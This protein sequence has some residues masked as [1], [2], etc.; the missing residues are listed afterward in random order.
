MRTALFFKQQKPLTVV[1]LGIIFLVFAILALLEDATRLESIIAMLCMGCVLLGYSISF[2]MN[3][4]LNHKKHFK[5]FGV[6]AF[7]TRLECFEPEYVTV[8]STINVKSSEWGPVS[9]MG[10][11]QKGQ[12][13][14]V[15]MFKGVKH[16]TV[17]RTKSLEEAKARAENLG[18][19]LNVEIRY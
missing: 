5:L 9:A 10:N 14:V 16:F 15:R 12:S 2:E 13:H 3:M 17:F 18:K 7:K 4:N 19:L 8:F 11:Q 1:I 6:T